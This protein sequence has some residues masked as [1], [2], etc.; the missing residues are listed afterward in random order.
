[1]PNTDPSVTTSFYKR[2][3]NMGQLI[4]F[5]ITLITLLVANWVDI[6]ITSA[7]HDQRLKAL[8]ENYTEGNR[9]WVEAM[10]K[11]NTKSEVWNQRISDKLEALTIKVEN[12]Q[13]K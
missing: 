2:E 10:E 11:A 8:E 13:D 5:L 1:M 6:S 12:K 9:K 7:R 4:G 3:V